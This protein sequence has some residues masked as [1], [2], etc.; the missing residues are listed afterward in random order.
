MMDGNLSA[1]GSSLVIDGTEIAE[2]RVPAS[3][4]VE[5]LDIVEHIGA[6]LVA[7]AVDLSPDALGLERGEA[8]PAP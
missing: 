1:H 5:A 8:D 7:C 6:G 4:I 3:R 2:H